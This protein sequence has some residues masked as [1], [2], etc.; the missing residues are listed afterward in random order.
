MIQKLEKSGVIITR[1]WYSEPNIYTVIQW[2]SEPNIYAVG[3]EP[4]LNE[5]I[6]ERSEI[7]AW[8]ECKWGWEA[9][10]WYKDMV[11]LNIYLDIG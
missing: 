5:T 7:L 4:T 1:K 10:I 2:Y 9:N 3:N 8:Q 11:Q 6:F